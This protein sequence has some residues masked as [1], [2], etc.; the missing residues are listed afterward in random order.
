MFKEATFFCN[1]LANNGVSYL[2]NGLQL[3]YAETHCQEELKADV[4]L[5]NMF[6]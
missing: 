5:T 6:D 4:L 2:F 3:G 1:D